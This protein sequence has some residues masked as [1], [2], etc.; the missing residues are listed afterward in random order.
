MFL[1]RFTLQTG[2]QTSGNSPGNDQKCFFGDGFLSSIETHHP[3]ME[4]TGI[5]RES[6]AN[7]L[8]LLLTVACRSLHGY[9]HNVSLRCA[10]VDETAALLIWS[11]H[12]PSAFWFCCACNVAQ[13]TRLVNCGL[14]S[15]YQL[16]I[17]IVAA[18]TRNTS[19]RGIGSSGIACCEMKCSQCF[20]NNR[21]SVY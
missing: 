21:T 10:E 8:L 18:K 4:F 12:V 9:F 19:G 7:C 17:G 16:K 1:L 13:R 5:Q 6:C 11:R 14:W 3:S 15:D 2:V 20:T